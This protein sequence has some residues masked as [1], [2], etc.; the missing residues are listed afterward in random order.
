MPIFPVLEVLV[1]VV[2]DLISKIYDRILL[3]RSVEYENL[4]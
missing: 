3:S 1:T 4:T 2:N